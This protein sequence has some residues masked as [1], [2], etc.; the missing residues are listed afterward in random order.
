RVVYSGQLRDD[1]NAPEGKPEN[2]ELQVFDDELGELETILVKPGFENMGHLL[3]GA[4]G[5][6]I[7]V[8]TE[9]TSVVYRYDLNEKS[10]LDWVSLPG[11]TNLWRKDGD[12]GLYLLADGEVTYL[13]PVTFAI[14][15]LATLDVPEGSDPGGFVDAN[16]SLYY[17]LGTEL[18]RARWNPIAIEQEVTTP[19]DTA[20]A[21]TLKGKETNDL[22]LGFEVLT[23][24]T[25]GTLTGTAPDLIYTPDAGFLGDD[26]FT[27]RT[28]VGE[29]VSLPGTVFIDVI[30]EV[31]GAD[32]GADGTDGGDGGDT[33]VT[34]G[35]RVSRTRSGH[36]FGHGALTLV[37]VALLAR[38]RRKG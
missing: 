2:S 8:I 9:P 25:H 27:F 16:D 19:K 29:K 20:V 38:R 33:T 32:A 10:L 4:P 34:G 11:M 21:V 12:D 37:A 31:A 28:T 15:P 1:P 13:D 36:P 26:A 17:S 22:A 24:P 18:F 35:C 6:I 23:E 5:Q 7:G 30:E 14:T 3:P